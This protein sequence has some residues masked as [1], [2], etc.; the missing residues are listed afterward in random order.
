MTSVLS[1]CASSGA[2]NDP[3][4]LVYVGGVIAF[5]LLIYGIAKWVS[6]VNG[7]RTRFDEKLSKIDTGRIDADRSSFI[8]F[9]AEIRADIKRIFERLP[10][11]LMESQSPLRLN[12]RGQK[13]YRELDADDWVKTLAATL[14]PELEDK[15]EKY[16]I[17]EFAF[18]FIRTRFEPDD[19][20]E[21][22]IKRVAYDNGVTDSD[23][24]DVLAISLRDVLIPLLLKP[25]TE[26]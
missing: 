19:E 12:N 4:P 3:L 9:M 26:S 15:T 18:D 6:D 7:D 20:Q 1:T 22:K 23:V 21:A 5:V 8:A 10:A 14:K 17:Q 24:K 2:E 25:A 16:D 13:V 11:P